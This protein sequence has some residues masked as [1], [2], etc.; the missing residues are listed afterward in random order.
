M[1]YILL[2]LLVIL[3]IFDF[4]DVFIGLRRLVLSVSEAQPSRHPR[5]N[6]DPGLRANTLRQ[7]LRANG[8][9]R[10]TR[11]ASTGSAATYTSIAG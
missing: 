4:V 11:W 9:P 7:D 1:C 3:Y 10:G 6:G 5:A 8:Y 2:I